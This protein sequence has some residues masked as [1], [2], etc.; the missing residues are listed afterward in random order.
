MPDFSALPALSVRTIN[1]GDAL[2]SGLEL[3]KQSAFLPLQIQE[4]QD[5]A[6]V[7]HTQYGNSQLSQAADEAST[8]GPDEAP[9]AWDA[10]MSKI[11]E[12][13]PIARQYIGR[14]SP[15]LAKQVKSAFGSGDAGGGKAKAATADN[16]QKQQMMQQLAQA[17]A[18]QRSQSL[19]SA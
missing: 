8:L 5:E 10:S 17:P 9:S 19:A 16:P 4:A 7:R 15:E 12:T 14:Y 3:K 6:S 11:A 18:Q 13:N 1:A 2:S